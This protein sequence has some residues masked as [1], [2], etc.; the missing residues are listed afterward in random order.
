[1]TGKI[2]EWIKRYGFAEVVGLVC[3]LIFSNLSMFLF[4]NLILAAFITSLTENLGFYGTI[5]FR[6]LKEHK[7]KYKRINLKSILRLSRNTIIEFGPAECLDGFVI[8]PFFLAVL[9]IYISNYSLA[10]F[11]GLI[12]ANITF[13]IPTIIAYESRKKLFK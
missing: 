4:G 5:I 9:P 2:K 1:M 7:S 6:D 8:R 10:I 12:L 3:A 11:I 13:Y